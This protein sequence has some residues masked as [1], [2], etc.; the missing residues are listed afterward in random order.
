MDACLWI[1]DQNKS[2]VHAKQ[3]PHLTSGVL[4]NQTADGLILLV[5]VIH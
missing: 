3:Q 5:R 2:F 4:K 1:K